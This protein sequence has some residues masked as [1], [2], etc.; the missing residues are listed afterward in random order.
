MSGCSNNM[1]WAKGCF[2]FF[3]SLG[4]ILGVSGCDNSESVPGEIKNQDS[5]FI[6][7]YN[8]VFAD[9]FRLPKTK[10]V[11]TSEGLLAMALEI[12]RYEPVFKCRLH[13]YVDADVDLYYPDRGKD[14]T[15]VK[16]ADLFFANQLDDADFARNIEL[17]DKGNRRVMFRSDNADHYVESLELY[18]IRQGILP[19]INLISLS[20]LCESFDKAYSPATIWYQKTG[21]GDYLQINDDPAAPDVDKNYRFAIPN[22]LLGKVSSYLSKFSKTVGDH[23]ADLFDRM[24]HRPLFEIAGRAD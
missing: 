23:E 1:H 19:G 18:R 22:G 17:I 24:N 5:F 11:E 12:Y 16:E 9:R 20:A 8:K 13:L 10:A 21:M 3:I 4:F 15:T 14:Y 7:S 2:I 6:I